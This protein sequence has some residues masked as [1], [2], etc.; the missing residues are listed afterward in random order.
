MLFWVILLILIPLIGVIWYTNIWI[1]IIFDW[2]HEEQHIE[3][4]ISPWFR[5]LKFRYVV[6]KIDWQGLNQGAKLKMKS[7]SREEE[8]RIT[9]DSIEWFKDSVDRLLDQVRNMAHVSHDFLQR[10]VCEE[11]TFQTQ[12]GTGDAAETGVITGI[13]WSIQ[14]NLVGFFYPK[15]K[16]ETSPHLDVI[17][18]FTR[19]VFSLAFR[20]TFR[21]RLGYFL[22]AGLRLLRGY[23]RSKEAHKK[24]RMNI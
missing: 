5:W 19:P 18:N 12:V 15:V 6:P 7:S 3:L 24:A 11:L 10:V 2:D 1:K 4:I 16:W 14:S 8:V 22:K 9:K 21:F 17:P 20:S 13:C 23:L